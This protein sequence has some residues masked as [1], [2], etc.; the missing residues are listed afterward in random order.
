MGA[1]NMRLIDYINVADSPAQSYNAGGV[2]GRHGA[3]ANAGLP[4]LG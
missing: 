2:F 4:S 3:S 1:A